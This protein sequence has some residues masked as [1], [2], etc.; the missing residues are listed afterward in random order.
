MS[1]TA[2]AAG[3]TAADNKF[4]SQIKYIVGNEACER[5]S[6]YGMRSILTVFMIQVL[7]MQEAEA[8]STYHLF[9]G[10]CYLFPLLGAFISDRFLGK[11]KT[12][13]Y[14]SLVY[15]SGHAVL[16]VWETKMGLYAGLALIALGSGGIK[17]CVSAHVGDQFKANQ[18]HL[19]K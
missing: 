18:T 17:P 16:A 14:L 19:L 7:L 8:T 1:Q 2:S 5:Y 6:Y 13:L 11:Y 9:A 15:C 4:P 3:V 12:I 10:A